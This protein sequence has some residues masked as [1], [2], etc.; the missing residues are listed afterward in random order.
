MFFQ[1]LNITFQNI[2]QNT[3][4]KLS[5]ILKQQSILIIKYSL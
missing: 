3:V 5:Q 2:L 1:L 4:V